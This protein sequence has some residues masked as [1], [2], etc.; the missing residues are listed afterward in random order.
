MQR[1]AKEVLGIGLPGQSSG[2]TCEL[3]GAWARGLAH[4]TSAWSKSTLPSQLDYRDP[5]DPEPHIGS[6]DLLI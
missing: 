2:C 4:S 5:V 1:V 6:G 3:E